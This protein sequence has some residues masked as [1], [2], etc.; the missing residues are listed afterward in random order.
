MARPTVLVLLATLGALG[1]C[2]DLALA[3]DGV[4]SLT[5]DGPLRLT[6][7]AGAQPFHCPTHDAALCLTA[8][9]LDFEAL[10]AGWLRWSVGPLPAPTLHS[11][12]PTLF[13]RPTPALGGQLRFA[14]GRE[15][16]VQITPTPRRC[17]PLVKL[18]F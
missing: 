18:T 17:A 5:L 16:S 7:D 4:S 6:S 9:V 1:L 10:N 11:A 2:D 14:R 8:P 15:L 12:A 3:A 13:T